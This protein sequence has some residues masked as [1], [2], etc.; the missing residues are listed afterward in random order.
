LSEGS[1]K[2]KLLLA[3]KT[4]VKFIGI[5]LAIAWAFYVLFS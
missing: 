1:P 2:E 5:S 4:F 3:L